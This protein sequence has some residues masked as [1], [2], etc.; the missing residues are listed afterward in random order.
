MGPTSLGSLL[1]EHSQREATVISS[2]R[3]REQGPHSPRPNL[4]NN[5]M[6]WAC[7]GPDSAL[8]TR[9]TKEYSPAPALEE[10]HKDLAATGCHDVL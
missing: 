10:T 2:W 5:H 1:S 3:S 7:F 8:G 4:F 6:L 9:N